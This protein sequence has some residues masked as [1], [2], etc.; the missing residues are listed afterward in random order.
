MEVVKVNVDKSIHEYD[1]IL[2]LPHHQSKNRAHM[3]LYDRAAQFSPFAALTGYDEAVKE[4]ARLTDAKVELDEYAKAALNERLMII[5]EQL[6]TEKE[7]A[8][9]YFEPDKRKDGGAYL[10]ITGCVKKIDEY[11]YTVMMNDKT[12]IPIEQIVKLESEIFPELLD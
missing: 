6:P 2:N 8:I 7:V 3:T 9:T 10:T 5:K 12:T 4:T 1:D 11:S